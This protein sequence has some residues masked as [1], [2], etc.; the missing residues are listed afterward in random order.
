M[1]HSKIKILLFLCFTTFCFAQQRL[2]E[3][4]SKKFEYYKKLLNT[5][6]NNYNSNS[7]ALLQNAQTSDEKFYANYIMGGM[8][9]RNGF[10]TQA[11]QYYEKAEKLGKNIDSISLQMANT[12]GLV[13]SYRR[14]GLTEQSN[15]AWHNYKNLQKKI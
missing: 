15:D 14:V 8:K 4:K 1:N 5:N 13:M 12:N 10:Y 2:D 3:K 7:Q 6:S 11:V 9:Y